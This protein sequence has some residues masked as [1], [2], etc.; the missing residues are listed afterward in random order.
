MKVNSEIFRAYDIRGIVE[1]ELSEEL[2]KN[3]GKAIGTSLVRQGRKEIC[4]CRDGRLSGPKIIDT[5]MRGIISTGCDVINIGMAPTPLLYFAT[6]TSEVVDGVMITGSHNPKNYNGFKIVFNQKSLTSDSI[7]ELKKMIVS[8]NYEIGSGEIKN[9]SVLNDYIKS[10][11]EKIKIERPLKAV[12]D[13]G[14]GVG[15]VIAPEAFKALGIE[16]IEIFCEVDG[17][18]PN[19]HPDPGNPK[20][21]VDL[22]KAVL[23]N[24]ADIGI[25]LDGDGDRLGVIDDLGNIIYPDQ[26]LS[27]ISENIL[28]DNAKRKIVFDVKCSTQLKKAI[29]KNG[30]IPVMSRTGHS[31]IKAEI[32]NSGAILGGEMS[33]HI[34]FNDNWFGFDDG[35]FS[36]LR[37]IE[38]L[39][40]ENNS[41][42]KS[43]SRYPQLFNTPELTIKTTDKEKFQIIEKLKSDFQ[44][45]GYERI[46]IDGI[47]L[48]N[49][50]AWGLARASN[51]T[52]TIVLRFEGNTKESLK[53]IIQIFQKALFDIDKKLIIDLN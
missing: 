53:E 21:M 13:C 51:T 45:D 49:N 39:A 26:Y 5:L 17:N 18:F 15:G 11:K 25:A 9:L 43:F 2:V 31:Y 44:F 6:F 36:A 34:F 29:E 24:S 20:N 12:L 52:P 22:S 28:K 4:V 50:L 23:E 38:I 41:S 3:L 14:N 46:L 27:L 40:K 1:E 16:L 32:L 47:R 10:L 7:Q 33:G 42:S 8:E 37:L 48:E 19:H 35:I 30:G